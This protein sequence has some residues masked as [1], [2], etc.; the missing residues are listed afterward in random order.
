MD[1]PADSNKSKLNNNATLLSPR[2]NGLDILG[3][4][5]YFI[6]PDSMKIRIPFGVKTKTPFT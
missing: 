3:K 4:N 6:D 2:V 1:V 5:Q